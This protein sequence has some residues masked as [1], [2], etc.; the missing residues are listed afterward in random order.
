M[1]VLTLMMY[2]LALIAALQAFYSTFL[3]PCRFES[4]SALLENYPEIIRAPEKR[5]MY[6]N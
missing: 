4:H 6:V 5:R 3:K 2:E 1:T